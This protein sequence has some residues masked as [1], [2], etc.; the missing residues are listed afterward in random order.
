MNKYTMVGKTRYVFAN[1]IEIT[2]FAGGEG[3]LTNMAFSWFLGGAFA[4]T[5]YII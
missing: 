2:G 4:Y 5:S 3:V 1:P